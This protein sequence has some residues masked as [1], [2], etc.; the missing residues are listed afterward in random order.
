MFLIPQLKRF[1]MAPCILVIDDEPDMLVLLRMAINLRTPYPVITT[2]NPWE[3]ERILREEEVQLVITD[4]ELPGRNGLA[5]LEAVQQL[6]RTIPVIII[7][8]YGNP[9]TEAQVLQKGA[10]AYLEKP[11]HREQL[12][13]AIEKGLAL[14]SAGSEYGPGGRS[15]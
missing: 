14:R 12:F 5:V 3:L 8:A 10:L 1:T 7:T 11:F 6:D 9:E 4:L 13:S 15:C 2:P